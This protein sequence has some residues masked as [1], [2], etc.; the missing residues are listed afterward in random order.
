MI[1]DFGEGLTGHVL[2]SE[3]TRSHLQGQRSRIDGTKG[4]LIFDFNNELT[5]ESEELGESAFTLDAT[6][7]EQPG[8]FAGSMADF[9]IAIENGTEPTV[10]A[11]RNMVTIRTI[12]AEDE[13]A[14]AGG[15]WIEVT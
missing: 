3:L 2:H 1:T 5:I 13:S 4:T 12:L 7:F 14:N 8:S 9:L 6:K 10:S 11:R 15:K